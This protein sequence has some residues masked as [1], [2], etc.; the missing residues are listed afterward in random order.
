MLYSTSE[1]RNEAAGI[2]AR[3][4]GKLWFDGICAGAH[5]HL[6][7][8]HSGGMNL[9]HDLPR[10]RLKVGHVFELQLLRTAKLVN[11]NRFHRSIPNLLFAQRG[12]AAQVGIVL[13][14]PILAWRIE[15]IEIYGVLDRFSFVRHVGGDAEYFTGM[16]ND[17]LTIDPELQGAFQNVRGLL[18][19]PAG[20]RHGAPL[21]QQIW[22]KHE[23]LAGK[24][25]N[26]FSRILFFSF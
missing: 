17:F 19:L 12:S 15:D 8:I 13:T 16:H 5:V 7:G 24:H 20:L 9:D 3:S 22:G 10:A 2:C 14:D 1:L 26:M 4:V 23:V 21:L 18:V 25:R 6:E 11:T